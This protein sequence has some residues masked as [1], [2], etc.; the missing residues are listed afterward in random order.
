LEIK[1]FNR[2]SE[3][4]EVEK[5]YG[6]EAVRWL[7][8]SPIGKLLQRLLCTAPI[9]GI[10]GVLQDSAAS[11]N[12]IPGFIKNFNINMDD[13]VPEDGRTMENPYSSFNQFFIRRFKDGKRPIEETPSLMPAFAEARYFAYESMTDEAK[14]PVKGQYMSAK[15]LLAHSEWEDVFDE[16]PLLLARLCPVDYHRFHYPDNGKVLDFYELHGAYH[17]VNPIALKERPE[18]FHINERAVTILQTENFGKLA[19]I[20][21]GAT[22][23]GKIVQSTDLKSFKRGEEK[24]YFLFGGSTVIVLGEKGKWKPTDDL[25][26]HTNEGMETWVP[27]GQ[28]LAEKL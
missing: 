3:Q 6:V 20:E 8:Q 7:Y 4:V 5:V 15:A 22:M 13:Y 17:S 24:G 18:I 16:G 2:I 25:I 21:V 14:V 28:K 23:V 27:L 26:K 19:Y 12:K 9:S 1:Y 11:A 10:Y